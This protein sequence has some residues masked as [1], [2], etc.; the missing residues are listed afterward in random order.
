MK[1]DRHPESLCDLDLPVGGVGLLVA[2][3]P[4][5]G[6]RQVEQVHQPRRIPDLT[7]LPGLVWRPTSLAAAALEADLDRGIFAWP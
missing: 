7:R 2:Y 1:L 6:R 3:E 4:D 5:S